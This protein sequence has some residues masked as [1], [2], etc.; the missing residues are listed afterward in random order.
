MKREP[1]IAG[2]AALIAEPARARMLSAL[3]GGKALTATELALEAGVAPSTASA[4]LGKLAGA[5]VVAMEKQGRHRYFR[6]ND[7]EIAEVLEGLMG[8]AARDGRRRTGPDDPALRKARV[9]YDHL[10]GELA[11]WLVESLRQ[12]KILLGRD[13]WAISDEGEMFFRAWGIDVDSLAASRRPLARGCLDWSERRFHLGGGL[14]AAVLMRIF[15]LR[16]ARRELEGRAVI[17]S[18]AGER[19]FR[20]HFAG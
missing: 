5:N 18:A 11:I 20:A 15:P 4:H 6:L 7:P 2:L 12:R 17:F 1:G 8:I 13:S 14:G 19:S 10:A 9:C 16:W 3:M